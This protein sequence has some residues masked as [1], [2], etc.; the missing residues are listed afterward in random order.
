MSNV[1]L[2][3]ASGT[4]PRGHYLDTV[5]TPIQI[6]NIR[7]YLSSDDLNYLNR[8]VTNG[9]VCAW[10]ITPTGVTRWNKIRP[11]DTVL[12]ARDNH[13]YSSGT[14]VGKIHNQT[15]SKQLWGTNSQGQTWEW[16]YF[17]NPPLTINIPYSQLNM[18]VG[19]DNYVPQG[20]NV[21][22]DHKAEAALETLY[23]SSNYASAEDLIEH[24]DQIQELDAVATSIVRKEQGLLRKKLL[25]NAS[26]G[27]CGICSKTYPVQFLIA[28]HIKKR[29]ECLDV[30]KADI[31]AIAMPMCLMGC[32]ALYEKGYLTVVDG[33]IVIDNT[34]NPE[35]RN[36]LNS[37]EGK[38]C[39]Y[40][41]N[42]NS[43]YFDWHR[44]NTFNG[45]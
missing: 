15:L 41:N 18:A 17:F 43:G 34:S 25:G 24:V 33:R 42:D 29:S 11:G 36:L 16:M 6:S 14:V 26:M 8:V 2:Q 32:D 12:F 27:K 13:Y 22:D 35:L 40:W 10:G 3:P 4:E 44:R 30:E 20:I 45:Q 1:I 7:Q 9:S 37:L 5:E 19:Y 28:A 23:N 38:S 31:P 21:L 39:D